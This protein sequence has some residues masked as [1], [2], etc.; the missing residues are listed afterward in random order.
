MLLQI[1][2][3]RGR[4]LELASVRAEPNGPVCLMPEQSAAV[5]YEPRVRKGHRKVRTGCITC[6]RRK[7]KCDEGKPVCAN[8][9]KYG[10]QCG[11]GEHRLTHRDRGTA[12][13]TP[14]ALA[15]PAPVSVLDSISEPTPGASSEYGNPSF[16]PSDGSAGDLPPALNSTH[17]EL[18]HNFTTLTCHTLSG[19]PMMR[20][21][22]RLNVPQVGFRHDYVMRSVLALSAL[23]M[24]FFSADRRRDSYLRVARSEHGAALPQIARALGRATADNCS[25]L[26]I[27]ASLT[28][29]YAWATP[30][31]PGD[32]FLVGSLGTGDWVSLLR[33]VRSIIE[34]WRAELLRGPFSTMFQSGV[35]YLAG[36]AELRST[37]DWLATAEHAQLVH[38]AALVAQAAATREDAEALRRSIDDLEDSFCALAAGGRGAGASPGTGGAGG[39]SPGGGA[40]RNPGAP[41]ALT[42]NVYSWLLKMGEPFIEMLKRRDP[43]ALVIFA[44]FCVVLNSLENWWWMQGWSTHLLQE[45]WDL[46]DEEHRVWIRWPIE[47]IGWRPKR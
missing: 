22:W 1:E 7:V 36:A 12:P 37:P 10:V 30:R 21:V 8:C 18:L 15:V 16:Q 33:G 35:R 20:N 47:E 4:R 41:W 40:L 43:L 34:T 26:Y 31:Q 27:S 42:S 6:K 32:L 28:F 29:I 44:H 24:S 38:L 3:F 17:L 2:L 23:H 25:A 46:L 14:T 45:I 13:S 9:L 39:G 5:P 19:D 11:Y